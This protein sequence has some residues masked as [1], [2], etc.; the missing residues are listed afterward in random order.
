MIAAL[1]RYGGKPAAAKPGAKAAAGKDKQQPQPDNRD[2]NKFNKLT[3]AAD[4][5][6]QRGYN[7]IFHN[8]RIRKHFINISKIFT[9]IGKKKL[10]SN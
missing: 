10:K 1:K 9:V 3:E 5:L 6:L 4:T 2:M 8:F 7:D